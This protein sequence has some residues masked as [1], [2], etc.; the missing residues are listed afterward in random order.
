MFCRTSNKLLYVH[1]VDPGHLCH[2]QE[3]LYCSL[4]RILTVLPCYRKQNISVKES[5]S[6]IKGFNVIIKC[7]TVCSNR[8]SIS[9]MVIHNA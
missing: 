2:L 4:P 9:K 3:I 6:K 8:N 7:Q 5:A 1:L